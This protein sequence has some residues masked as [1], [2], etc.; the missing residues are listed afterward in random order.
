MYWDQIQQA[1]IFEV[2]P[3]VVFYSLFLRCFLF[4]HIFTIYGLGLALGPGL[5]CFYTVRERSECQNLIEQ[6]TQII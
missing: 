1:T 3:S 4:Q 6:M 5:W 2:S